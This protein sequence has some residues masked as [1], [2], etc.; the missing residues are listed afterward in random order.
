MQ[1]QTIY[2]IIYLQTFT[3]FYFFYS[4]FYITLFTY[5]ILKYEEV[6]NRRKE[7]TYDDL[8]TREKCAFFTGTGKIKYMRKY[9]AENKKPPNYKQL[10]AIYWLA[11]YRQ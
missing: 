8:N 4:Y 11:I 1:N 7:Q 3:L 10:R 5:F 2:R 6:L 9:F